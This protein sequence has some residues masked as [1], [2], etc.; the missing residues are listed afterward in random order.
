M[1]PRIYVCNVA[2]QEARPTGFDLAA[3]VEALAANAARAW[4]TSSSPTTMSSRW[5][6]RMMPCGAKP[7]A[8]DDRPAGQAALAAGDRPGPAPDPRRCRG[9]ARAAPPRSDQAGAR[10]HPRAR[11]RDR[12][13]APDD[14]PIGHRTAEV[15]RSERD[16]VTALRDE[17][18]AIDP[19]RACDRVAE[20]DGLGPDP[21]GRGPRS[22]ACPSAFWRP[23]GRAPGRRSKGIPAAYCRTSWL[24]ADSS[25]ADR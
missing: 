18:A 9:P 6:R 20:V 2:T 7:A 24:R 3:H 15:T 8:T 16:L 1:A 17:L 23:A 19:S 21:I 12:D 22:P 11:W 10:D 5:R 14:R 4:S 25:P 13:P